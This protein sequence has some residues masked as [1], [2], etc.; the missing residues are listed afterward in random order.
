MFKVD[1]TENI[2]FRNN[3]ANVFWFGD[4]YL[5]EFKNGDYKW[6]SDHDDAILYANSNERV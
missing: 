1:T 6:F 4:E 3:N 5:V 2:V